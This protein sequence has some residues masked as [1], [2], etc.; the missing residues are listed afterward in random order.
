MKYREGKRAREERWWIFEVKKKKSIRLGSLDITGTSHK[1]SQLPAGSR[2]RAQSATHSEAAR[3]KVEI[4]QWKSAWQD[5]FGT[6]CVYSTPPKKRY[7]RYRVW[8]K[9]L[10]GDSFFHHATHLHPVKSCSSTAGFETSSQDN[11]MII[12]VF[13][14][15]V[16]NRPYM[17]NYEP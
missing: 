2:A 11:K 4:I 6:F 13:L 17:W 15:S 7:D 8:D 3:E 1:T 16:F 10:H 12:N 14:N 5:R 9:C